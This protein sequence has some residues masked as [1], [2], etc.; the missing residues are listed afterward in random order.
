MIDD[1][2]HACC[3]VHPVLEG[4]AGIKML[5]D[6]GMRRN[7]MVEKLKLYRPL[8]VI[9]IVS[10]FTAALLAVM[11]RVPMMDVHCRFK[12]VQRGVICGDVCPI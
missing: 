1:T 5:P 10:F 8:I 9:F 12:I 7:D 11:D 6:S 4:Q 2:G 3:A